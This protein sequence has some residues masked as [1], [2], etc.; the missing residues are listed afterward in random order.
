MSGDK[1]EY[2]RQKFTILQ[3]ARNSYHAEMIEAVVIGYRSVAS[4]FYITAVFLKRHTR[5]LSHFDDYNR[6]II[7]SVFLRTMECHI[8]KI[9]N[10]QSG[11][12]VF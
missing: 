1:C 4:I 11:Y 6:A 10:G 3:S 7:S 8:T 12:I 5:N 9:I 2:A